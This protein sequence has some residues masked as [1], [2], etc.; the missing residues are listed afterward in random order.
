MQNRISR[1]ALAVTLA[2]MAS[3]ASAQFYVGAQGGYATGG[4][5]G[6]QISN[7]LVNNLGFFSASTNVDDGDGAWRVYGG[8]QI[9]PWLAV[10]GAYVDLGKSS[11]SSVVEPP[12]TID[13][14]L[15]VTAW[16]LGVAAR[17]E[18]IPKLYGYGRISAAWTETK[19]SVSTSGFAESAGAPKSR[20]TVPAYAAG[21]E[22]AFTPK[23]LGRLEYEGMSDVSSDELGGKFDT[24]MISVGIRYNF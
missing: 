21:L 12:G 6:G 15:R 14:T 9:L 23:F 18:F 1:I 24:N 20:R 19:S 10:E 5:D 2:C 3:A 8:Y 13:V 17:Y 4:P 11:W 16:T 22:Y 7:D